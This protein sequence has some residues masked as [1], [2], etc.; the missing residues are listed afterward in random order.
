LW[1]ILN[2][3][4]HNLELQGSDLAPAP[5]VHFVLFLVQTDHSCNIKLECLFNIKAPDV[6]NLI[7]EL[8]LKYGCQCLGFYPCRRSL[9]QPITGQNQVA[10]KCRFFYTWPLNVVLM[11]QELAS[12]F[13]S[14]EHS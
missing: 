6:C 1:E 10:I 7:T 14:V 11:L 2:G 8:N 4:V 5:I 13:T 9:S 3:Y 12:L